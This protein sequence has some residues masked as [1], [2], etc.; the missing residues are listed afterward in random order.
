ML[1]EIAPPNSNRIP[2]GT[3]RDMSAFRRATLD[4]KRVDALPQ[5][6]SKRDSRTLAGIVVYR[7]YRRDMELGP[8]YSAVSG[9]HTAHQYC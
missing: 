4:Q 2:D 9:L 1:L 5:A 8:P 6:C 7:G 3:I